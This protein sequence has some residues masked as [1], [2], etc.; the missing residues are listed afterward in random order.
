MFELSSS[1]PNVQPGGAAELNQQ[2]LDGLR[3]L[4]WS[5]AAGTASRGRTHRPG[6]VR[7]RFDDY[8]ACGG[9]APTQR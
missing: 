8:E 5:L 4:V 9:L 6:N 3:V 2:P 1:M 7:K